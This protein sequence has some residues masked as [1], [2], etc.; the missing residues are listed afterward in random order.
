MEKQEY[1]ALVLRLP[2]N[3]TYVSGYWPLGG[4]SFVVLPKDS[5]PT[6]VSHNFE[7]RPE[8]WIS[9]VRS[10]VCESLQEVTDPVA[11]SSKLVSQILKEKGIKDGKLGLELTAEAIGGSYLKWRSSGISKYTIDSLA[12]ELPGFRFEDVMPMLYELRSIKSEQEVGKLRLANRVA[13]YGLQAFERGLVQGKTE[14]ELAAEIE[15]ATITEGLRHVKSASHIM[16][17]AFL[18]SGKETANAHGW[19]YGN[20]R[21]KFRKGD[22]AML[23][24]D[25]IVDGYCSDLTRTFT[26]G[27]PTKRQHAILE[28][29]KKAHDVAIRAIRP[30]VKCS[31]VARLAHDVIVREGYGDFLRHYVGHG[32]GVTIWEPIPSLHPAS[33]GQLTPGM[34]HSIEPGLYIE[35][36]GGVRTEDNVL[37][38]TK[39]ATLLSNYPYLIG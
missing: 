8:T 16:P 26:V 5:E 9:D 2:E 18:V 23:E 11:N 35:G 24:F 14:G 22:F 21:R 37:D 4:I 15:R 32:L 36:Y 33:H 30:G 1:D 29:V 34:V 27:R 38:T 3:V 25:V 17:C 7:P 28:T 12:K 13:R 20:G 10:Y 19:V 39:G 31:E 6:F